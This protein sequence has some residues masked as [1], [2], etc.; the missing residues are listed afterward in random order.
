M[1]FNNIAC[2]YDKSGAKKMRVIEIVK[3]WNRVLQGKVQKI[4]FHI[5]LLRMDGWRH[6][7]GAGSWELFPPSFYRTHTKEEIERITAET[8][9]RIQKLINEME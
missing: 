3:K 2:V 5:K 7:T 6:Y 9:E 4:L 1:T 8:V